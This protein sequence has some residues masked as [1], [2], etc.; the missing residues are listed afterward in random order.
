MTSPCPYCKVYSLALVDA[1]ACCATLPQIL[2]SQ[3]LDY[4][5]A[6]VGFMDTMLNA[7]RLPNT[8]AP[9]CTGV[10]PCFDALDIQTLKQAG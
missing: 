6:L 8:P 3:G 4:T 1:Y 7:S 9:C 2:K 10:S 5:I